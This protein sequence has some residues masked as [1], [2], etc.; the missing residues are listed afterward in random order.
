MAAS[1]RT[2][3]ARV[4]WRC[5]I[6]ADYAN[7]FT[8]EAW[9]FLQPH[10]LHCNAFVFSHAAFVPPQ[11]AGA[12][13]R[14]IEP[15]IDPLS[16]KNR[17]LTPGRVVSLL[18]QIGLVAGGSAGDGTGQRRPS[19]VLGDAAPIPANAP[20][21]VQV[22]RWDHL[23][24]MEGVLEGFAEHVA[25]HS[26]AHLALVGPDVAAV[27][28]DPE[29]KGV[30]AQCV[31]EWEALPV[32]IRDKIRL[33][34]LPMEDPNVNALMVNAVQRHARIVVQ[35]SLQEGFG[36]TLAEAMWKSRP[37][38]ASAVG[39]LRGQLIPGTGILIEDP[40]DLPSFGRAVRHLLEHPDEAMT[41][42]RRGRRHVRSRYLSDRHLLDYAQ[43]VEH[44]CAL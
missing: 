40:R 39:G 10:L 14:I 22:S 16:P 27:T 42:G 5:H 19:V 2:A 32:R 18:A 1:L 15:S 31:A 21:V 8:E 35:K 43:L 9:G 6:G 25:G 23:K 11:L 7:S 26:K 38:V 17:P 36:L 24:D 20:L 30:L 13:V 44:V 37:V 33:V 12:D 34:A 28:D 41:M 29:G 3:G 4:V